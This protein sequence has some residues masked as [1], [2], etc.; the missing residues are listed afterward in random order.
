[1]QRVGR[2]ARVEDDLA[3]REAPPPRPLGQLRDVFAATP[4]SSAKSSRSITAER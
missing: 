2:I 4:R 3:G 1:M